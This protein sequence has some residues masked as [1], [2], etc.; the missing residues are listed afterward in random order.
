[1]NIS[2][3]SFKLSGGYNSY[4]SFAL[5]SRSSNGSESA[6][7]NKIV[8]IINYDKTWIGKNHLI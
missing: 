2:T 5:T 3:S 4:N 6:T 7:C 1:M 8:I